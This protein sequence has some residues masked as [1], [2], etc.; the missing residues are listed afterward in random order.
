MVWPIGSLSPNSCLADGL[1]EDA[2]GAAGAQLAVGEQPARRK[3]PVPCVEIALSVPVTE[4][5]Q[6]SLP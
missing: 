5:A 2:D 4:V 3:R 6:F 1:A